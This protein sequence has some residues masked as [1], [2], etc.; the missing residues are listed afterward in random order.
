M[1]D[2]CEWMVCFVVGWGMYCFC[3]LFSAILVLTVKL[4]KSFKVLWFSNH[5]HL[6]DLGCLKMQKNMFFKMF[7]GLVIP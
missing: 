3:L 1:I 5:I 6:L 4:L 7:V 2:S